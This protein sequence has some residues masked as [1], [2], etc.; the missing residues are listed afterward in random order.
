[1]QML[2]M[3][4]IKY[5]F[6]ECLS[7]CANMKPPTEDFLVTVQPRPADM[8]DIWSSFPQTIFCSPQILLCSEKYA[9]NI[10]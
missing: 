5:K 2:F 10:W 8:G 9:L 3:L 6:S 4:W 1:M 7:P